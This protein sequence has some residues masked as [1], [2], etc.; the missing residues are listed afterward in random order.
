MSSSKTT[1]ISITLRQRPIRVFESF[2]GYGGA[3][4][5]LR[6]T[7]YP[8]R[9]VG[10]SE[11][12][13]TAIRIYEMNHHGVPN[14]GDITK[15]D[16]TKLPDF[17]LFT[18]GFPCQPFT[19]AGK[20]QGEADIKGRGTLF[21]DIVRILTVKRPSM[22]LLENVVGLLFKTHRD[23]FTKIISMLTDIGYCVSYQVINSLDCGTPQSRRRVWIFGHLASKTPLALPLDLTI[24]TIQ[25]VKLASIIDQS[26]TNPDGPS[27]WLSE[28]KVTYYEK[29]KGLKVDVDC[30]GSSNYQFGTP[31]FTQDFHPTLLTAHGGHFLIFPFRKMRRL[32]RQEVFSIMG[33]RLGE[34]VYGD[35]TL[36]QCWDRCGNGWDIN[37]A[38]I[39]MNKI[40]D[41]WQR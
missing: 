2:A 5:G 1:K 25:Q 3:S 20:R 11:I 26:E 24:P 16:E 28:E 4:F 9:I 32:R 6:R 41:L 29:I 34:I 39:L 37:V 40:V 31:R 13:P 33:F 18:G 7:G 17:D 8:H 14:Y 38:E 12:D 35:L 36:N 22:F 23:T 19:A 21:H 27:D 30:V 15:I 10:Y